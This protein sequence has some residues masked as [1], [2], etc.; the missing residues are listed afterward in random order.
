MSD[1]LPWAKVDSAFPQDPKIRRLERRLPHRDYLAAIG[2]WLLILA[3]AWRTGDPEEG[4][5]ADDLLLDAD[6]L[7]ALQGVHLLNA[8]GRIP[9]PSWEKWAGAALDEVRKRSEARA[10]LAVQGGKA[11]AARAVRADKGRFASSQA[12]AGVQ[13]SAGP[14]PAGPQPSSSRAPAGSSLDRDVDV[15]RDREGST[16]VLLTKA[17]LDE[18]SRFA[19]EGSPRLWEPTKRAWIGR[20]LRH[21]PTEKQREILYE[22]LDSRPMDLPRWIREAPSEIRTGKDLIAH[23]LDRWHDILREIPKEDAAKPRSSGMVSLG[24]IL[25]KVQG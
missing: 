20:G 1:G 6:L 7:D 16:T 19:V 22:I 8:D 3:D 9:R 2:A 23:V 12:P 25:A 14:D 11:R 10:A 17:Q 5:C 24:E 15:E 18:W 4:V 13:P 21:P